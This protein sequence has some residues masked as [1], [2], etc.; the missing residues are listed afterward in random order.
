MSVSIQLLQLMYTEK[1]LTLISEVER[2]LWPQM[3]HANLSRDCIC[4][5]ICIPYSVTLKAT[6]SCVEVLSRESDEKKYY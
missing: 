6:S 5:G 4:N 3:T 2:T 1:K